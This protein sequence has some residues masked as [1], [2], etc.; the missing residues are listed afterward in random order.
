MNKLFAF[1]L[2]AAI[3]AAALASLESI[4]SPDPPKGEVYITE[5]D[6]VSPAQFAAVTGKAGAA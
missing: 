6:H 1:V 3:N 2:S 4:R 5:L